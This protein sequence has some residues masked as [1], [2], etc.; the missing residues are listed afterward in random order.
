LLAIGRRNLERRFKRAT[1][2]TVTEYIQRVKVEAA[3]IRLEASR[4][5]VNEVMYHVGYTDTKAF[6]NTHKKPRLAG[7]FVMPRAGRV[8]SAPVYTTSRID[9]A[10]SAIATDFI[11]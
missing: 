7:I 1:S 6:R 9:T 4:E 10:L 8:L 2:N 5:N 11:A 3:K